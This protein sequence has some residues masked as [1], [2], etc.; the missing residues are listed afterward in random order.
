MAMSQSESRNAARDI[1]KNTHPIKSHAMYSARRAIFTR[2]LS[3]SRPLNDSHGTNHQLSIPYRDFQSG[4]LSTPLPAVSAHT[5]T[6][7]E[8]SPDGFQIDLPLSRK[9]ILFVTV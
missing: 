4:G 5:F 2:A 6:P 7:P 3:V 1:Y 9:G 8:K